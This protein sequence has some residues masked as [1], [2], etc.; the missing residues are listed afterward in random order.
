[1]KKALKSKTA[2]DVI[3]LAEDE[4]ALR[5][6]IRMNLEAEGYEV[7]EAKDAS[8][9]LKELTARK[10]VNL[11]ILDIMMPGTMDGIELCR[12]L[13]KE[14]WTFPVIFLTARNSLSDK[15][16]GFDAGAD[17]YLGKPFE[18]E[19]LLARIR[20]R[21]RKNV[22]RT[23]QLGRSRLDLEAG[24]AHSDDG[25]IH[26]F[27][28]RELKILSLLCENRG[29]PVSR[30]R[31]LDDVWGAEYPTNR[32]IDNYIVKFRKIFEIDP[33]NPA[34]FITRHG[35]GYELSGELEDE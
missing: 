14:G 2:K 15:L 33:A 7:I 21:L 18:L 35:T 8:T 9:A 30:D 12:A 27:N 6:G 20:A 22:A 34:L 19:E 29:K 17:D 28:R 1:M 32:T 10:H 23:Y 31:I 24:T 25:K 26:R 3:L 16:T 4:A 5:K 13:R 11:G